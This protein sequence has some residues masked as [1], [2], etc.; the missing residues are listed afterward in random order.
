MP[1]SLI[2]FLIFFTFYSHNSILKVSF[3]L[4]FFLNVFA[5]YIPSLLFISCIGPTVHVKYVTYFIKNT[6]ST[7]VVL[8]AFEARL[9]FR[10]VNFF[11]ACIIHVY[12]HYLRDIIKLQTGLVNFCSRPGYSEP[13]CYSKRDDKF[14]KEYELPMQ[15]KKTNSNV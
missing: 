4:I 2:C 9:S 14:V 3:F 1:L 11:S 5:Q 15:R 8:F 12:V 7:Q 10:F 13:G 6:W